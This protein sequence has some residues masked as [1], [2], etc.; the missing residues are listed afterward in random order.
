[1]KKFFRI[2]LWIVIAAI[3]IGTF[4]FLYL[5]SKPKEQTFELVSPSRGSVERMAVLT[6]TIEPRNEINIKPQISGII[7]KINVEAGDMVNVGDVIAV[8]KVVPD[9]QSISS[10]EN[11]LNVARL[12]LRDVETRHQRN[13]NLYD[14]K[15][16]S[17]EEYETT[18]NELS[19]AKEEVASA[20]DAVNIAKNGV[21]QYNATEASTQVRATAAGIVLDVPVKVGASVI[22]AN[23]FNDGTTIATVAD[24]NDLIFKGTVDETEVGSLTVGMPMTIT[25][26]ALPDFSASATIEFIAPK[27]TST[28]GANSFELKAALSAPKGTYI[29]AG[30]SANASV[31]LNR[32]G[33]V[34]R[35]PESVIEFSGDSSFVYVLT[36]TVHTQQFKRTPVVTGISDGINIEIKS[37]VNEK[38]KLRGAEITEAKEKPKGPEM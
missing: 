22:Q 1:M 12:N 2:L 13:A 26:G 14:R 7:T 4:V 23:T 20:Q 11:R 10:A 9:A 36:D 28:N 33:D 21:S 8:I 19:R 18:L 32:T 38:M 5:N 16:I 30:Y 31:A 37:G 29:R 27:G 6:G 24:M 17:R 15:V 34:I 3:V 35:V 25:I